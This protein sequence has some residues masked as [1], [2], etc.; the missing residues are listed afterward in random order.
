MVMLLSHSLLISIEAQF[1]F[2]FAFAFPFQFQQQLSV[3]S[4]HFIS[5]HFILFHFISF[6]FLL[7]YMEL[8]PTSKATHVRTYISHLAASC[9]YIIMGTER[10]SSSSSSSSTASGTMS[11]SALIRKPDKPDQT[12][13]TQPI[14]KPPLGSRSTLLW[15]PYFLY[16]YY[17][18][19]IV[20]RI[21]G[22]R[23]FPL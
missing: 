3:I 1:P 21:F 13:R 6:Y 20:D 5:F 7:L 14:N 18:N 10:N 8:L 17:F 9:L 19:T 15:Q 22:F 12:K 11:R 4:L 23:C 16:C 2:A